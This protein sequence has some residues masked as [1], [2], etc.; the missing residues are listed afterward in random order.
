MQPAFWSRSLTT[1]ARKRLTSIG[2][3]RSYG[4]A[5][6][7]LLPSASPIS[8]CSLRVKLTRPTT[9]THAIRMY[10]LSSLTSTNSQRSQAKRFLS[11]SGSSPTRRLSDFVPTLAHCMP[12]KQNSTSDTPLTLGICNSYSLLRGMSG[13]NRSFKLLTCCQIRQFTL[14]SLLYKRWVDFPKETSIPMASGT[15]VLKPNWTMNSS[16]PR[17]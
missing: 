14:M 10:S 12:L 11:S 1:L 15:L 16:P 13:A 9:M 2:T 5:T 4:S 3:N 17:W 8:C 7:G 6:F